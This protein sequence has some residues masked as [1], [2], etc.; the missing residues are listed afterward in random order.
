MKILVTAAGGFTGTHLIEY[1]SAQGHD[2]AGI[3]G[4]VIPIW[5]HIDE[6]GTGNRDLY[7]D[8]EKVKFDA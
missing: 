3:V 2:V 1:L 7:T 5:F 8:C 4:S 6:N